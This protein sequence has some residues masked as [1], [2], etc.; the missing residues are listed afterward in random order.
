MAIQ[1]PEGTRDLLPDEALFW[2]RFKDTAAEVFGRYGYVLIE[3]P[4][5]EQAELFV[6]GIG[7]ATDVVSKEMF[8]ALS[9]ENLK[10]LLAGEKVKS[11]SRLSLRPEGTAGVVRA[12]VEHNLVPQ[13][14][15][16]A[17]LMYAGPMFQI[18]RASCRERV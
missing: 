14:A 4:L 3:T 6:R 7:E 18:G 1:A 9:G 8:A 12:V 17:K 5:I 11:K 10:R 16:P 13:G 2:T 15:A